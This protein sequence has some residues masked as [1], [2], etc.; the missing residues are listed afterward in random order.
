[1]AL[2][3]LLVTVAL[4]AQSVV[5]PAWA[6]TA[7]ELPKTIRIIVP[8]APGGV[9]DQLARG[10]AQTMAENLH[11]AIVVENRPGGGG[12]IAANAVK[13]AKTDGSSIL[14]GSIASFA[15]NQSLYP[16]I[17]GGFSNDFVPVA[18]LALAPSLVLASVQSGF[19]SMDDVV[20]ATRTKTVNVASQ[21]NG[22][23]AHI[24]AELLKRRTGGQ[25]NHIPYQGSV[26]ALN[27]L[28]GGQ[29]DVLLDPIITSGQL[30]QSGRLRA[31]AIG[32]DQRYS[33][34]PDVPTLKEL[35]WDDVNVV[36]WFGLAAKAGTPDSLVARLSD[37]AVRA[38]S[39]PESAARFA[40]LGLEV[41]PMAR[42]EFSRFVDHEA[43]KWGEIIRAAGIQGK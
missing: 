3:R 41:K 17:A 14:F 28:M 23:G 4:A 37:E 39:S 18:R 9:S 26:P 7:A 21:G 10:V 12:Q 11:V 13:N 24:F 36:A 42:R 2:S 38:M 6:Q 40:D 1:M 22:S 16:D 30:V 32:A 43:K 8:T 33:R 5:Y 29:V 19:A 25:I 35:G 20:K 34:M 15:I 27:A 31:I